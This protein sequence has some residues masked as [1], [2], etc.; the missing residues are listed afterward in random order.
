MSSFIDLLDENTVV[1]EVGLDFLNVQVDE[2]TGDLWCNV[3]SFQGLHEVK[4]SVSNLLL[5][6][7]VLRLDGR[8]QF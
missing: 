1:G 4:D 3:T 8:N 5:H 7:G 6:E 2:H